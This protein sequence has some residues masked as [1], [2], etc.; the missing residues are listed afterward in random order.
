MQLKAAFLE[1]HDVSAFWSWHV[2]RSANRLSHSQPKFPRILNLLSESRPDENEVKSEA[3]FQRLVASF[4]E[5]PMQPRTPRAPSDRGRYPEEA[6]D[7]V[8]REDSP[9]DDDADDE[10]FTTFSFTP[11]AAASDSIP[12]G[13]SRA[14][15]AG[16]VNGDDPS[17]DSP[18]GMMAMDVD[19]PLSGYGSPSLSSAA[20]ASIH[21]WRY[22]PPPTASAVR[23]NKRKCTR[24]ISARAHALTAPCRRRTLRAVP[25]CLEAASRVALRVVPARNPLFTVSNLHPA[26]DRG[27]HT[28]A[29]AD[30][31]AWHGVW[32]QCG[33]RRV[34][35][36]GRA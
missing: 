1:S 35:A 3:Q 26:H 4:S 34:V 24:P 15:P 20:A 29:H 28:R 10:D 25:V 9:S 18:G 5:L 27:S 13:R 6:G 33:Q 30:S 7:D 2:Y 21:Q 14:T 11:P 12:I 16:S 17:L 8:Q 36:D 31:A 22:T 23:T 32:L 19:I